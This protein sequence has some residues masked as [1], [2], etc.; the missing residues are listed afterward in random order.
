MTIT[1]SGQAAA[2]FINNLMH[3]NK[4]YIRKRDEIFAKMDENIK[5]QRNGTNIHA[6]I[7]NLDLNFID[8]DG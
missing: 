8:L 4:E 7:K 5:I 6:E 2:Q 3:P 1:L